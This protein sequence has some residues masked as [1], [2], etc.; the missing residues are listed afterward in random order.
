MNELKKIKETE[1]FYSQM[2]Q[3]RHD[4]DIL[5]YNLSAFLSAAQSILY[6]IE[7]ENQGNIDRKKWYSGQLS[8]KKIVSFL[9]NKN[10]KRGVNVHIKPIDTERDIRIPFNGGSSFLSVGEYAF[11]T[12]K[13]KDGNIKEDKRK[14]KTKLVKSAVDNG[15]VRAEYRFADWEGEEDVFLLCEKYLKHLNNIIKDG[16]DKKYLEGEV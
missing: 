3:N 6:Y 4:K 2:K 14:I 1:Y 16:I 11:F 12:L 8:N 5:E 10:G 15:I 7:E 9:G 13:D